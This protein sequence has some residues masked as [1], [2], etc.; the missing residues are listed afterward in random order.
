MTI[1]SSL[2][3]I[4]K[5]MVF[6]LFGKLQQRICT[7]LRLPGQVKSKEERIMDDELLKVSEV[8]KQLRVDDTTVRRWIKDGVLQAITLPSPGKRK[9]YRI[10]QQTLNSIFTGENHAQRR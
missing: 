4:P 3:K 1:L 8:A 5:G 9:K 10:K 2:P 7:K 6:L